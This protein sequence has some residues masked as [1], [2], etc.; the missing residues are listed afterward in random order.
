MAPRG[1]D[2]WRD[3]T[4][5]D[6]DAARPA[7]EPCPSAWKGWGSEKQ[8]FFP[9]LYHYEPF[10]I[11]KLEGHTSLSDADD[12]TASQDGRN[13]V[14]LDRSRVFVAAEFDIIHHS[15]V[16]TCMSKLDNVSYLK[17]NVD[18]DTHLANRMNVSISS[19][20]FDVKFEGV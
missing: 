1:L 16:Q 4:E 5:L 6:W 2:Q 17:T 10:P 3:Y 14:R 18:A 19:K 12:I 13:A 7:Y 8:R 9:N 20:D 15:R 11:S